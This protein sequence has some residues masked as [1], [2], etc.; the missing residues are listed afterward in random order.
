M[1]PCTCGAELPDGARFCHKCGRP[2]RDEDRLP[3]AE[4]V[5]Q[6]APPV[7]LPPPATPTPGFSNPLAVRTA[8]L[9]GSLSALLNSIP[10]VSFG[11]CLWLVGSGFLA[12]YL[13]SRRTGALLAVGGGAYLG[14]MT[15]LFTFV[16]TIFLTGVNF[17]I[18]PGARTGFRQA[19]E[20]QL[21]KMPAQ[22]EIARQV[23]AFL[24]SP[25]GMA[26]F[27]LFYLVVA[28]LGMVALSIAGGALG[29]KVMEKD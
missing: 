5:P 28:F 7:L 20:Q 25:A 8:L 26:M 2:Q 22:D 10:F 13:Y 29:A 3:A 9:F 19:I 15:G 21:Q 6:E 16:I 11:C 14:W 23:I 27:L 17:A 1:P 24:T 12:V 18:Q 4:I